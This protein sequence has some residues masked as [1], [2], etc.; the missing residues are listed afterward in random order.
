M[1]HV[2]ILVLVIVLPVLLAATPMPTDQVFDG[3]VRIPSVGDPADISPLVKTLLEG[4]HRVG[5]PTSSTGIPLARRVVFEGC[6][7]IAGPTSSTGIPILTAFSPPRTGV[8]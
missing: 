5:G 8:L 4:G 1:K 3:C 6:D 2:A 7:R